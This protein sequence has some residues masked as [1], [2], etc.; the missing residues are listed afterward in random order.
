MED[1]TPIESFSGFYSFLSN[2]S[3]CDIE[4]EGLEYPSVENAYQAAK[5]LEPN[6]RLQFT[7]ISPAESKKRG[8]TLALRSDW[9]QVKIGIMYEL[10]KKKFSKQSMQVKLLETSDR[11]LIEGNYWKDTFWG[12]YR[13]PLGHKHG[14]NHLGKLL[15]KIRSEIKENRNG[16]V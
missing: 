13:D 2:F 12:V 5:T 7:E 15:M 9:D 10:L 16:I 1:K 8:R 14:L 3:Y 4:F 11:E 6:L